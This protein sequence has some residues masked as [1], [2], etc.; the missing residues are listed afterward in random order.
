MLSPNEWLGILCVIAGGP[1]GGI[2]CSGSSHP[3]TITMQRCCYS[4]GKI[5]CGQTPKTER[6]TCCQ[7]QPNLVSVMNHCGLILTGPVATQP[8]I[9]PSSDSATLRLQMLFLR[10]WGDGGG[11][12][13]KLYYV[14]LD[15]NSQNE[16]FVL[17]PEF[18]KS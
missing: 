12:T 9:T 11:G 4:K 7:W 8:G 18:W 1:R 15:F 6:N 5:W 16:I 2:H 17:T 13:E 10:G 14:F 3:I